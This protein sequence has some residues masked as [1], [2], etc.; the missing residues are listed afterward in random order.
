M[1]E[2]NRGM[3][4]NSLLVWRPLLSLCVKERFSILRGLSLNFVKILL[5]RRKLRLYTFVFIR[6]ST[7][8]KT[9]LLKK[10]Y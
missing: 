1:N 4:C 9:F 2:I 7:S 6:K 3:I 10:V 5:L 8:S